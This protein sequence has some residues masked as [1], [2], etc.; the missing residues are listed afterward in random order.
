EAVVQ[1]TLPADPARIQE[2]AR[3]RTNEVFDHL[4]A[5]IAEIDIRCAGVRHVDAS[6]AT[7][8]DDHVVTV[9]ILAERPVIAAAQRIEETYVRRED[10]VVAVAYEEALQQLPAHQ[11][12]R[13]MGW[14]EMRI[15]E[16]GGTVV[17]EEACTR[18]LAGGNPVQLGVDP[19]D[20]L[21]RPRVA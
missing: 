15:V 21:S 20:V 4:A 8:I 11:M 18:R 14:I 19:R 3:S 9:E 2:C 12:P 16:N 10:Q 6:I 1:I 5:H 17:G 13:R 7:E